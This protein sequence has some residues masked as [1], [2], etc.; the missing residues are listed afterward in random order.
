VSKL[1]VTEPEIEAALKT[2][3]HKIDMEHE[4]GENVLHVSMRSDNSKW[5]EERLKL[6]YKLLEIGLDPNATFVRQEK[7]GV[8][9]PHPPCIFQA[10]NT[11]SPALV[12][13]LLKC[14][15]DIDVEN[16]NGVKLIDFARQRAEIIDTTEG[17]EA[18]LIVGQLI[19]YRKQG[20]TSVARLAADEDDFALLNLLRRGKIS[21]DVWT[22]SFYQNAN[23]ITWL[24]RH[25]KNNILLELNYRLVSRT[26]EIDYNQWAL[27]D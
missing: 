4:N 6:V 27:S 2:A 26:L 12:Q 22:T 9:V 25:K 23:T 17:D 16:E 7:D 11:G 15:A 21:E 8:F 24:N 10:V 20:A 14:R 3:V 5:P 19:M 1:V 18:A 13:A